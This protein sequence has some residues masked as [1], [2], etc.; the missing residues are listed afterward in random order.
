MKASELIK[1]I[2]NAIKD[3]GDIEICLEYEGGP[4]D[5]NKIDYNTRHDSSTY[6]ELW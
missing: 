3:H 5:I 6:L 2:E 1:L 4:V